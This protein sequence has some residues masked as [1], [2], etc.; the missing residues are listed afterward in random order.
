MVVVKMVIVNRGNI[1]PMMRGGGGGG[2]VK[3][4]GYN[5]NANPTAGRFIRLAERA[6][7]WDYDSCRE[8]SLLPGRRDIQWSHLRETAPDSHLVLVCSVQGRTAQPQFPPCPRLSHAR[9]LFRE[10]MR[11]EGSQR[12]CFTFVMSLLPDLIIVWSFTAFSHLVLATPFR[13][14][15]IRKCTSV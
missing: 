12:R 13:S 6:R 7:D 4:G 8:N 10:N 9:L 11:K 14:K 3:N 1:R 2:G 5:A 15:T